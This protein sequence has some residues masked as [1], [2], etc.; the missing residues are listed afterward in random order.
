MVQV[1]NDTACLM[2]LP[3]GAGH[4][5]CGMDDEP[6]VGFQ[7]IALAGFRTVK[8]VQRAVARHKSHDKSKEVAP[9]VSDNFTRIGHKV[10]LYG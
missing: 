5:Q 8:L 3:H 9:V 10:S 6:V 7:K 2:D 1:T 4:I